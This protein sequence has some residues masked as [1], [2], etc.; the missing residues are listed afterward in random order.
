[1]VI[2]LLCSMYGTYRRILINK[3]C[4]SFLSDVIK[5]H[6]PISGHKVVSWRRHSMRKT[7]PILLPQPDADNSPYLASTTPMDAIFADN[8]DTD[9]EDQFAIDQS[10]S[11]H[12]P[13][14]T[15]NI[16]ERETIPI[17]LPSN[18][19]SAHAG[20]DDIDDDLQYNNC[21]TMRSRCQFRNI[22]Q[23]HVQSASGPQSLQ[24]DDMLVMLANAANVNDNVRV[25]LDYSDINYVRPRQLGRRSE[26][27]NRIVSITAERNS[28]GDQVI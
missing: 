2:F 28:E 12:N 4:I 1:M 3:I 16:L 11:D 14:R 9:V 25:N 19:N 15:E 27:R 5:Q 6:K 13:I 24:S 26:P 17:D 8:N 18:N 21:S 10:M 7:R 23:E 22:L 20:I